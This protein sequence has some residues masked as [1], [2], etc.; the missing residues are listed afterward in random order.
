MGGDKAHLDHLFTSLCAYNGRFP[1]DS[2]IGLQGFVL[3]LFQPW[4][5]PGPSVKIMQEFSFF[6]YH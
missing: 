3:D 6:T 5:V 4:R 1:V 2:L